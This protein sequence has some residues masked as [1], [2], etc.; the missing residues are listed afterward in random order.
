MPLWLKLISWPK[1]ALSIVG[2]PHP[3]A[4]PAAEQEPQRRQAR[5]HFGAW[6]GVPDLRLVPPGHRSS[7]TDSSAAATVTAA[8]AATRRIPLTIPA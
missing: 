1:L 6:P 5:M 7:R 2:Y 8:N 3:G 4:F